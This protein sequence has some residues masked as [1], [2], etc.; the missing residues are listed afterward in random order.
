MTVIS[1]ASSVPCLTSAIVDY[2][3][4]EF[5]TFLLAKKLASEQIAEQGAYPCV[6]FISYDE[7]L[8]ALKT[9]DITWQ[10]TK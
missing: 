1:G 2:Y 6:G 10:V 5:T 8:N 4:D 9:L 3:I 7:Y